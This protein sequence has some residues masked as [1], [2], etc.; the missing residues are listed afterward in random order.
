MHPS[1]V[2]LYCPNC[3]APNPETNSLCEQCGTWIPKRYLRV[4]TGLEGE[5]LET[6]IDDRFAL[7]G[8]KV[9]L[10][11]QPG[12]SVEYV[13]DLPERSLPYLRLFPYR[14]HLPQLFNII[15]SAVTADLNDQLEEFLLL[16]QAPLGTGDLT[17]GEFL[18]DRTANATEIGTAVPL[19]LAWPSAPAIRQLH[20]LWQMARLW[21][22]LSLEGVATS[23]LQPELLRVE[24]PVFRL[25]ELSTDAIATAE[26]GLEPT[27]INLG[28]IW[29]GW[30]PQAQPELAAQL[31]PLCEQMMAGKLQSPDQ[32]ISQL[33]Q[34]LGLE[35]STPPYGVRYSTV[36]FTD[37][38]P[39]R[40]RNEDACFPANGT[41]IKESP[42]VMVVICDGVG[43]HAG[44]DVASGLAISTL[45]AHL[46]TDLHP[47]GIDPAQ[48][49]KRE[50]ITAALD[51]A[52]YAA[53]DLICQRNDDE[54]RL[55]RERMGTTL[56]M[57]LTDNHQLYIA[58]VGDSRAYWITR[59][60]CYQITLDDDVASREVR[61]GYSLYRMVVQHPIAG[62]LVQAMGMLPSQN[63]Q[64][65]IER[66]VIDQ[67]CLFLL[68]SDGLSDYDRVEEF[69]QA[70]LLPVLEAKVDLAAAGKRLIELANLKNGHDNV[71]IGL[72]H[73]QVSPGV[74][75][76]ETE[77][78]A[79]KVTEVA[80]IQT[81]PRQNLPKDRRSWV[82][83]KFLGMV[84]LVLS[85]LIV[86]LL[87]EPGQRWLRSFSSQDPAPIAIADPPSASLPL[88]NPSP[89]PL[90]NPPLRVQSFLKLNQ[91]ATLFQQPGLP[92][93]PPLTLPKGSVVQVLT[94][95]NPANPSASWV[96]LKAC[97]I[98]DPENRLKERSPL[99]LGQSAWIPGKQISPISAEIS[100]L[101]P[102]QR[103]QCPTPSSPSSQT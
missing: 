24:G 95:K 17:A 52:I 93:S 84:F 98:P 73:C 23:L 83:P 88:P 78:Q 54:Q 101:S 48:G 87:L 86:Y 42:Q 90:P 89:N 79:T 72:I 92:S 8:K 5:V 62:S 15:T 75:I 55:E 94:A 56:V 14:L 57:G 18:P 47:V 22:P 43:G 20:W 76:A 40:K 100:T 102:D 51:T 10:D 6:M 81:R 58:H 46:S 29:S 60:G 67:D 37:Q 80:T 9:V 28:W 39:N 74:D 41:V 12:C 16:E 82:N 36:T 50:Q 59:Q 68:C 53:N 33:E 35:A 31:S 34:W 61:L 32:L 11:T 99:P 71:T 25:L 7:K 96:R 85:G 65:T 13:G 19:L 91:T 97:S 44:G 64:P 70:V 30:L 45:E 69:W 27:L 49:P 66:F 1:P 77:L 2:I 21:Q 38:G 4:V 3:S 26:Q 63:L 103:S